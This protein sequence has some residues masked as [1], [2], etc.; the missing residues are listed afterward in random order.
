MDSCLSMTFSMSSDELLPSDGRVAWDAVEWMG[1]GFFGA[2]LF[3]NS[4]KLLFCSGRGTRRLTGTQQSHIRG[5]AGLECDVVT[6]LLSSRF[7]LLF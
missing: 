6:L 3:P 4:G 1:L 7:A 5:G 2:G